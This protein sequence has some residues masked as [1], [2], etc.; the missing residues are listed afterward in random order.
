MPPMNNP[1]TLSKSETSKSS[2]LLDKGDV[3][4]SLPART[5][6]SGSCWDAQAPSD[7]SPRTAHRGCT[8]TRGMGLRRLAGAPLSEPPSSSVHTGF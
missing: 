3:Q 8:P 7:S 5:Q 2:C 4:Q 6:E 1:F